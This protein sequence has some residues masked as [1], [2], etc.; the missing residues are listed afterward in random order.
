ML[1]VAAKVFSTSLLA[2]QPSLSCPAIDP[3]RVGVE[4][5]PE[6][7]APSSEPRFTVPCRERPIVAAAGRS[8]LPREPV[9]FGLARASPT[10]EED[11]AIAGEPPQSWADHQSRSTASPGRP[12][13]ESAATA[14][15]GGR[16]TRLFLP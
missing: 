14:A 16:L 8:R 11:E 7:Q 4:T 6:P 5:Q 10:P 1:A 15:G 2:T 9:R 3:S 13:Q 12:P